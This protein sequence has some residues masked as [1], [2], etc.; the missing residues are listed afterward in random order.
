[1]HYYFLIIQK[2]H[3]RGKKNRFGTSNKIWV[4]ILT[5]QKESLTNK[6]KS[7]SWSFPICKVRGGTE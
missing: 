3:I 6:F 7:V 2:E 4:L 5:S 1:M